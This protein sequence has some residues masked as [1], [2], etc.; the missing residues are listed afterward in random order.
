MLLLISPKEVP[1]IRTLL[2]ILLLRK[3]RKGVDPSLKYRFDSLGIVRK[4][5][6]PR[7]VLRRVLRE[8]LDCCD[9]DGFSEEKREVN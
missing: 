6:D 2:D 4:N 7:D 5:L 8:V 9:D 1:S 3:G